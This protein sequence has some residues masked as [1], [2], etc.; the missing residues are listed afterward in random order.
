[1]PVVSV[2]AMELTCE[3]R[4]TTRYS[5]RVSHTGNL[6]HSA[7]LFH[8]SHIHVQLSF[9]LPVPVYTLATPT[10]TTAR[11]SPCCPSLSLC[12]LDSVQV[13][14]RGKSGAPRE[15]TTHHNPEATSPR[16]HQQHPPPPPLPPVPPPLPPEKTAPHIRHLC[17]RPSTC[18]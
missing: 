7:L 8:S 17:R 16:R 11:S 2:L 10:H 6:H 9:R 15:S 3:V 13:Q 14:V 5:S 1:M 12:S 4:G 18:A